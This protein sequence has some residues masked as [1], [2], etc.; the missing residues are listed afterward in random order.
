VTGL[1]GVTGVARAILVG[2]AT[3]T[4]A[5]CQTATVLDDGRVLLVAGDGA[6]LYDPATGAI[7][8]T[9]APAA[10]RVAH[11]ATLLDDGRVLIIG[12][13]AEDAVLASTELFDADAGGFTASGELLE[14]RSL[15]TATLLA[16]GGVLVV[17][18]GVVGGDEEQPPL[19]TAERWDP[20]TGAFRAAGSLA[21]PRAMHSATALADGSVLVAGGSDGTAIVDAIERWDPGTGTFAPA[22]SLAEPSA[23][24]TATVLPDGSVL[25]IGG[26]YQDP[27]GETS[28]MLDTIARYDPATGTTT[29]IGVL[30]EPRGGHTATL[31]PDGRV[32]VAGGVTPDGEALTSAELVDPATGTATPTGAMNLARGLHSAALLPDGGVLVVGGVIEEMTGE[33]VD[34]LASPER[35]DA[36][37]GTFSVIEP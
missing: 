24:H 19:A 4:L 2:I 28:V 17:G 10:I 6:R 23:V 15:H 11:S 35:Y 9:G 27:D 14:G 22:G 16:D 33:D 13:A 31:L 3:V 7:T 8:Q 1:V 30:T 5:A 32:L 29:P 25:F 20:A 21:A 36:E 26:L 34:L 18:G 37:L 12:G